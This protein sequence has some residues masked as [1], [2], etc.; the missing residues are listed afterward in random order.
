MFVKSILISLM[1]FLLPTVRCLS[2]HAELAYV[3]EQLAKVPAQDREVLTL[4]FET[5]LY[6]NFAY[7][8]FGEKPVSSEDYHIEG[9][10]FR[11]SSSLSQGKKI[12]EKYAHLFQGERFLFTF[13]TAGD[14]TIIYLIN[15]KAFCTTVER[16][17]SDFR[18]VIGANVTPEMLLHCLNEKNFEE[19]LCN[20]SGLIGLL[21]GFGHSN[22]FM[23]HKRQKLLQELGKW[24]EPPFQLV[25]S[26]SED[27]SK[28]IYADPLAFIRYLQDNHFD[29]KLDIA[30]L[31]DE[32]QLLSCPAGCPQEDPLSLGNLSL[33]TLPRFIVFVDN[34]ET[35]ALKAHYSATRHKIMQA[36]REGDFL[37]ITLCKLIEK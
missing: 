8:L 3:K 14:F 12:W 27:E 15:K 19:L 16:H 10:R 37:E 4:F 6:D 29:T 11:K 24:L 20:H 21:Y 33:F 26:V 25:E 28:E 23:F 17:L 5:L 31:L 36:Y 2:A 32:M 34:P 18:Q 13:E 7:T 35:E 30:H 9:D 22:S 1:L